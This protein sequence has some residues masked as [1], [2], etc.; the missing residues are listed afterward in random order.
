MA[1]GYT[2]SITRL[3][4]LLTHM[5]GVGDKTAERLAYHLLRLPEQE[6]LALADAIREVKK[7]VKQCSTCFQFAESDPCAICQN[8]RRDRSV[9]CV[10]EEATDAVSIEQSGRYNGLYHVLGGRLAPLEGIEPEDLT[11]D[12]LMERLREGEATE[13]I[14]ATNPDMEGEA[15]ALFVC[16]AL[17]GLSVK[18]T[19]LARGVPSGS[20][21]EYANASIL[22]DALEGRREM[23][24]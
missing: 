15:T 6:A 22:A 21:L 12:R 19:R 3:M 5:P 13:V 7:R 24:K 23:K 2:E 1:K 17:E 8:P 9:I 11:V 18:V 20:H 16:E 10:V 4:E 14:L